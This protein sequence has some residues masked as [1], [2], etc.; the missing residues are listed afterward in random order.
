MLKQNKNLDI[1]YLKVTSEA[2]VSEYKHNDGT[3]YKNGSIRTNG[4]IYVEKGIKVG[5]QEQVCN[6]MMYYDGENFY[7]YSEKL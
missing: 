7:G 3:I 6:G 4:G 5:N 1:T 2:P